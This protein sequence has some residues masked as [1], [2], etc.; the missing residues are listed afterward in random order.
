M[1]ATPLTPSTPPASP[2]W[3]GISGSATAGWQSWRLKSTSTVLSC[4]KRTCGTAS[5][6]RAARLAHMLRNEELSLKVKE[7]LLEHARGFDASR[8]YEPCLD[9]AKAFAAAP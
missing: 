5:S 9:I 7:R 4:T 3:L 6:R 2:T 1:H 8:E